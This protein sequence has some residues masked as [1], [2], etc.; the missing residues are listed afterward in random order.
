MTSPSDQLEDVQDAVSSVPPPGSH[1][2]TLESKWKF[3]EVLT[4]RLSK[5]S[6]VLASADGS[7][8]Y[9]FFR[10]LKN[11]SHQNIF[12]FYFLSQVEFGNLS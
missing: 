5:F 2:A 7:G 12:N 4:V 6:L 3:Q 9:V 8:M 11:L 10:S 1:T